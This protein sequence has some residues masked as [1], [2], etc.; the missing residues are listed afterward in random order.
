MT[1]SRALFAAAAAV[2]FP[3]LAFAGEI[4]LFNTTGAPVEIRAVRKGVVK[5]PDG[6]SARFLYQAEDGDFR[7]WT[8]GD[9][10]NHIF[11][12]ETAD[13]ATL[14]VAP[15]PVLHMLPRTADKAV[16][17]AALTAQPKGWP[18][19]PDQKECD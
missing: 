13:D 4:T 9:R 15:G 7:V 12:Y 10:C 19:K 18:M 16:D 5:I 14:Q 3:V 6:A 11:F 17:P 8:A 1:M 2:L